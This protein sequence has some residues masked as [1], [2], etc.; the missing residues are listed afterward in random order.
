VRKWCGIDA[1]PNS[2]VLYGEV[3]LLAHLGMTLVGHLPWMRDLSLQR[4][5]EALLGS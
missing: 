4:L 2:D 5:C 1:L 3:M